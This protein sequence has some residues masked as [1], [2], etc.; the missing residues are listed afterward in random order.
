MPEYPAEDI[1]SSDST[2]VHSFQNQD[3][4][5]LIPAG[6]N[7]SVKEAFAKFNYVPSEEA[8]NRQDCLFH[9]IFDASMDD[10]NISVMVGK[11]SLSIN[12]VNYVAHPDEKDDYHEKIIEHVEYWMEL[13]ESG[14]IQ[15]NKY[16]LQD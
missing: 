4:Y 6:P 11:D 7:K 12:G 10:A 13:I 8:F 14:S 1:K 2:L 3:V 15:R 9:F 16:V 5:Y